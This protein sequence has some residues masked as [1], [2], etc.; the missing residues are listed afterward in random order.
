MK[1]L[2][3]I[4]FISFLSVYGVSAQDQEGKFSL[5]GNLSYGTKIESLGLGLRAQYG[6]TE[7]IRGALEYKYYLDRRNVSAWGTTADV[8][9]VFGV[10]DAVSLYPIGGLTFSRWTLDLGR[11]NIPG[12]DLGELE[13]KTSENRLGLNLGFGGQIALGDN[14]FL[15]IE[16]K[17]ALIKD[18]TQFVISVGFM[19]QF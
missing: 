5:A 1:K 10:S 9:Y 2:L 12:V 14:T 16:A 4:F 19:Y 6:F 7:N 15:Q 13:A 3:I 8:H 18:Y 11:T 17:E